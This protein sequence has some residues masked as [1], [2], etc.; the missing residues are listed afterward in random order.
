MQIESLSYDNQKWHYEDETIE[1]KSSVELVLLF[2][3]TDVLHKN[4]HYAFLQNTYPNAQVIGSSSSGNVL[5]AK[6]S[7]NEI[8]ATAISLDKGF[9]KTSIIDFEIGD[10]LNIIARNLVAKFPDENLKS[11]FIISDG[12]NMNGT[13]LAK[14]VN[15]MKPNVLITGG[16]AGDDARFEKTQIIVNGEVKDKRVVAIGFYGKSLHVSSGCYAGWDEFGA[17]RV[18][19]KSIGNIVYEIDNKPALELYKKY[20]GEESKNL[21][22]SGL[23]FPLSIKKDE[24][25]NA[26]IRTLLAVDEKTQ[27]MTF[28]GDVPQDY[29]AKLMKTD[30]DGLIDGSQLA[31]KNIIQTNNKTALGLVVSC[32]GRKLVMKDLIDEELEIIED[33]V[34]SNVHLTGFYSY[35]ELA[36]FNKELKTCRLHNQTMTLTVIYED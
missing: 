18:I 21:P 1:N 23:R 17:Q 2:G 33:T 35:G 6:L 22:S 26:I 7:N 11:I 32:V 5:G 12:L 13:I 31:A 16:L 8:I 36:P 19:T 29:I 27:S 20:L 14:N 15:E 25:S 4:E 9:I 30:I 10:D 28:A 24:D 34:G 3:D